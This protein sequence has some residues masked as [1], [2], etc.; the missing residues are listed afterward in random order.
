MKWVSKLSMAPPR[1]QRLL[2]QYKRR[3][4]LPLPC[5][6]PPQLQHQHQRLRPLHLQ[7]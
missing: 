2:L 1:Q 7:R 3:L 5:P 4:L 6:L